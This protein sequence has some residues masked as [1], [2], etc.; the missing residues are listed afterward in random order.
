VIKLGEDQRHEA[1]WKRRMLA[2]AL[3]EA[4]IRAGK[5]R[6]EFAKYRMDPVGFGEDVFGDSYT[7]DVKAVMRSVEANPITVA[8]SSM[9]VGKTFSAAKIALW[10]YQSFPDSQVYATAAPPIENLRNL[11]WGEI[12]AAMD[13]RPELF[14]GDTI[15]T[16]KISRSA[17]CYITG[18]AIPTTGTPEER[19]SK[20]SG[21][22]SKHLLF[23]VDEGDAVPEEVYKGIEGCMSGGHARL[24]IMFNPKATRGTVY[25][26]EK[27]HKA[28]VV[29]LSALRHPNVVTGTDVIPGAVT[30]E[31]VVRRINEWTRPLVDG[32]TPGEAER[33]EVPEFLVGVVAHSLSGEAYPP[34]AAGA[35]VVQEPGFYYMVLGIYP[36]QGSN[37]LISQEWVDKARSR[38]DAWVAEYGDRP[39]AGIRPR[40]GLDVA[41]YGP[42]WNV[43]ILR[44]GSY[45]AK[46][47]KIWQGVDTMVTADK[48]VDVCKRYGVEVALVDA[49]G[50]GTGVAPAMARKLTGLRAVSVKVAG[51]PGNWMRVEQGEFYSLRDQLMYAV[52]EWLRTDPAAM[53]PNEPLLV[54]ELLVPTYEVVGKTV[55]V[56]GKETMRDYLKRSPNYFDALALTFLPADRAKIVRLG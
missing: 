30:R 53:L 20:F 40:L 22:H 41:E 44:Y 45:V 50:V 2:E 33:F 5:Q 31:T 15:N 17:R 51:K 32:E 16:L 4:Q 36:A 27:T 13:A 38:H 49:T 43:P 21:K 37:Q 39:P 6:N 8:K 42:D 56:M 55:R 35:R 29:H 12:Q 7:E 28:N 19:Q 14:D 18:V 9:A 52:R 11:L 54:Q 26:M 23:I 48:A 24:L 47:P 10:W 25:D 1:G 3:A 34:L 46:I